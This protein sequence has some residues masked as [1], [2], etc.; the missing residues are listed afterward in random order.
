[1]TSTSVIAA[2]ILLAAY[3]V[4]VGASTLH[5]HSCFHVYM[6]ILCSRCLLLDMHIP[7]P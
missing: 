1:M 7:Q 5:M 2:C 4:E 3:R 6:P